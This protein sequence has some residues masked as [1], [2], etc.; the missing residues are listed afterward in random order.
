MGSFSFATFIQEGGWGM[1]PV[2]LL[3]IATLGGAARYA[4]RPERRWLGF[5]A[6]LWL[7]LIAVVIHAVVMDVAAVF[8]FLENP[9]GV[10]DGQL[11]RVLF[12]GLKESSR[13]A[14][15]GGIFVALAPLLAADGIYRE[16]T[17]RSTAAA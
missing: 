7:T 3:G 10:P 13:P 6:A 2:M 17:S 4:V 8:R 12:V 5:A 11:A 1:W 16:G 14:A 15:L 9:A